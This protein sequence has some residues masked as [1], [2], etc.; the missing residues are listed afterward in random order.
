MGT[1]MDQYVGFLTPLDDLI[2]RDGQ[3]RRNQPPARMS[4]FLLW[5][6]VWGSQTVGYTSVEISGGR[7]RSAI[8]THNITG[9]QHMYRMPDC[10]PKSRS[11]YT[12]STTFMDCW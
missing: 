9:R 6:T 8:T 7:A 1:T 10:F 5:A 11:C 4:N 2:R 12:T 3:R